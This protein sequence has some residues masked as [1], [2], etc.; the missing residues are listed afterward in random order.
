MKNHAGSGYL[1]PLVC[2][3]GRGF[4]PIDLGAHFLIRP[5]V[6]RSPD[7][8]ALGVYTEQYVTDPLG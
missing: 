6:H 4:D 5:F 7:Q 3:K 2:G 1:N 8:I